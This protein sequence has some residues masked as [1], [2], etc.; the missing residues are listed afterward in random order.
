MKNISFIFTTLLFSF[1]IIL[2]AQSNPPDTV[3]TDLNNDLPEASWQFSFVHLSDTHIGEGQ[4]GGDYG[5][6]GFNDNLTPADG[7]LPAMRL[8]GAV[9]WINRN[10]DRL[11]IKFVAITGDLTDSGE[12]S[13]FLKFRQI[14]DSLTIPYIPLMG[15]HDV[16]PYT[17]KAESKIP[18][19]DSI[20][21]AVFAD[22]FK[23]LSATLNNWN[24]GTRLTRVR[25]PGSE[26]YSYFQ[27]FS[28]TY[29]NYL[30]FFCDFAPR[31]HA[32]EGQRGI[33]PEAD[34]PDFNGSSWRYFKQFVNNYPEKDNK[35]MIFFSHYPL[36]K[37]FIGFFA[38]FSLWDY[39]KITRLLLKYN[40]ITTAWIAGH[41]HRDKEY[42]IK[43]RLHSARI[44][45]GIET[46]ANADIKNGH[47]RIIKVWG[48]N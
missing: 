24:D 15:N 19:G 2:K 22:R 34:V 43:N 47:F 9:K 46:N 26:C 7:G 27:N 3:F 33:G 13:E 4:Q 18:D 36:T 39:G 48:M 20:I 29:G 11:K 1:S 23:M 21:N 10:A 44:M 28:F 8:S 45:K 38:S 42:G 12:K 25:N 35:K 5:T 6:P 41:F 40:T 30:F 37:E 32:P 17:K 16:W 14:L 31:Y